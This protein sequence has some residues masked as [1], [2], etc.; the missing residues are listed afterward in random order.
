MF[1]SFLLFFFTHFLLEGSGSLFLPSFLP[2]RHHVASN[3]NSLISS[4]IGL[5]I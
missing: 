2:A 4:F 1:G 5:L 3:D